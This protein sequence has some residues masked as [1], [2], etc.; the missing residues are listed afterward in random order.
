[1][2]YKI[3]GEDIRRYRQKPRDV[4]YWKTGICL[5]SLIP[6]LFIYQFYNSKISVSNLIQAQRHGVYAYFKTNGTYFIRSGSWGSR[7]HF[8]GNYTIKDS[9]II[10]DRS[11]F[12]DVLVSNTLVIRHSDMEY[13]KTRP[14]YD[15]IK[16][17]KYLVQLD[18]NG[19]QIIARCIN[20]YGV[21]DCIPYKFEI[22]DSMR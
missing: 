21:E 17:D 10:L 12:D 1:M 8:Y 14:D 11:N 20:I 22:V 7:K 19:H 18:S 15:R 13:E 3:A 16:T 5:L 9:T 2:F 6:L 4:S